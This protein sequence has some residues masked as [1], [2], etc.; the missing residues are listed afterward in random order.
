MPSVRCIKVITR[1]SLRSKGDRSGA[2]VAGQLEHVG[3]SKLDDVVG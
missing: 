3:S 2:T 1:K